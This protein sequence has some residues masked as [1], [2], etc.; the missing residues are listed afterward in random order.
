LL[1]LLL[2]AAGTQCSSLRN[3]KH[4]SL[5]SVNTL[6]QRCACQF[7]ITV[8]AA[9]AAGCRYSVQQLEKCKPTTSYVSWTFAFQLAVTVAAAAAAGCRYSVQQLEELM[10][11]QVAFK[12][13]LKEAVKGSPVSGEKVCRTRRWQ[14]QCIIASVTGSSVL[15]LGQ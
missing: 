2:L 7:T 6:L 14:E 8:A 3:V 15:H 13:L 11:D 9:A 10:N 12:A 1:L 4:I 5:N